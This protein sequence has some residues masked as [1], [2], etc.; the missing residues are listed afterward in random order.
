MSRKKVPSPKFQVQEALK[1]QMRIGESKHQAKQDRLPGQRAPKG[2]FNWKTQ[3][4]YLKHGTKFLIWARGTH[5]EKWL[6]GA[7][8][9]AAEWLHSHVIDGRHS[10][11]TLL[12]ERSALRKV[13]QN[14][15]LALCVQLPKRRKKDLKRSRGVKASDVNFSVTK[16][17]GLVDFAKATGLR[18]MEFKGVRVDQVQIRSDGTMILAR[19]KGKGGRTRD[20]PVLRG[21]EKAV[22]EAVE[23]ALARGDIKVWVSVPGH[24][25]VHSYRRD[26]AQEIYA[27]VNGSSYVKGKPNHEAIGVSSRA[28]GHNREDIIINSYFN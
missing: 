17:Q 5:G 9:Y 16:N 15:D 20:V 14:Q 10:A 3:G 23:A 4:A 6:V 11:H 22:L 7:E 2:I 27:R 26:Y 21:R 19:I 1:S 25:D 24:M 12:L 18:R 13:Y 8:K 28:L